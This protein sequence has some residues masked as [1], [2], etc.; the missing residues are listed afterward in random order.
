MEIKAFFTG[1]NKL[2][3]FVFITVPYGQNQLTLEEA[4]QIAASLGL[5][6]PKK[7]RAGRLTTQW[8]KEGDQ[9]SANFNGKEGE[10]SLQI[11]TNLFKLGEKR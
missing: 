9:V 3:S 1:E 8:G 10:H 11:T 6:D 7:N 5:K 4:K 2:A